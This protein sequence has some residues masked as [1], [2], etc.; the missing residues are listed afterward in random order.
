TTSSGIEVPKATTVRPIARLEIPYFFAAEDE[1]FTRYSAPTIRMAKPTKS[2]RMGMS[3]GE[4][5]LGGID[6][7]NLKPFFVFEIPNHSKYQ[8]GH[9]DHDAR[10]TPNPPQLGHKI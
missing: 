2:R 3:I 4:S 8:D 1:P 5:R 9:E 10:I 7:G 6:A